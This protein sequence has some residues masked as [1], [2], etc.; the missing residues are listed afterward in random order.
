MYALID[1]PTGLVLDFVNLSDLNSSIPITQTLETQLQGVLNSNDPT[2][3]WLTNGA[4]DAPE[5]PMSTG[6][7]DQIQESENLDP[8]W[9]EN[10]TGLG[11][12]PDPILAAAYVPL[13]VLEFAGAWR[14]ISPKVHFTVEDLNSLTNLFEY[15]LA[16]DPDG[17]SPVTV[18]IPPLDEQITIGKRNI[19]YNSGTVEGLTPSMSAGLLQLNFAGAYHLPY[20][21]CASTNLS[22]WI[23]LGAAAPLSVPPYRA[24]FQFTDTTVSNFPTRFYQIRLP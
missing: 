18:I 5:S 10:L 3:Y 11:N 8:E 16:E 19:S 22:D 7:V 14:T 15:S 4:T 23:Q 13:D 9:A 17:P 6:I 1:N 24:S 20:T 12:S 2:I 21:I